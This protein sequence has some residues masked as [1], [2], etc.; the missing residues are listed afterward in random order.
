MMM[1][2]V[3]L[4]LQSPTWPF[5]SSYIL[6]HQNPPLT[7]KRLKVWWFTGNQSSD[8]NSSMPCGT[9]LVCLSRST[10][11]T[12]LAAFTLFNVSDGY[13]VH[14]QQ[15][16]YWHL[17]Y[18]STEPQRRITNSSDLHQAVSNCW[19]PCMSAFLT[20]ITSSAYDAR[21]PNPLPS[22]WFVLL[23]FIFFYFSYA[24]YLSMSFSS[25][26]RLFN[27]GRTLLFPLLKSTIL[28]RTR[29]LQVAHIV[30]QIRLCHGLAEVRL[31]LRSWRFF[32]EAN[33]LADCQA[34]PDFKPIASGGNGASV[35]FCKFLYLLLFI[36]DYYILG[37]VGYSPSL[38]EVIVAHQGTDI[39]KLFVYHIF[40]MTKSYCSL[41]KPLP[42]ILPCIRET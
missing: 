23:D 35:Q 38:N 42:R 10:L 25:S 20:V 3:T 18:S 15:L 24:S 40:D 41:A 22:A 2:M 28:P 7:N 36:V 27:P 30:G 6:F 34:N 11:G 31:Q 5:T 17:I 4:S 26:L 37:Y 16:A 1:I 13:A 19:Y 8:D 12:L 14:T 32:T 21:K 33:L 29:Y 39:S 9:Y